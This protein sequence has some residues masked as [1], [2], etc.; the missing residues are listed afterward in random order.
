MACCFACY[1]CRLLTCLV[2]PVHMHRLEACEGSI[3]LSAP[4]NSMTA[5]AEDAKLFDIVSTNDYVEAVWARE[6]FHRL[7]VERELNLSS[8]RHQR[9]LETLLSLVRQRV[10]G[11][12]MAE[13][14]SEIQRMED[15]EATNIQEIVAAHHQRDASSRSTGRP[16]VREEDVGGGRSSITAST[17]GN[18]VEGEGGSGGDGLDISDAFRSQD[19][20]SGSGGDEDDIVVVSGQLSLPANLSSAE[21]IEVLQTAAEVQ[22]DAVGG[23]P[24]ESSPVT[25]GMSASKSSSP[26]PPP[27]D[28]EEVVEFFV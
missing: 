6:R 5:N 14:E 21:C 8:Q 9:S 28:G 13:L 16:S 2:A 7:S 22:A 20:L 3:R 12:V 17:G 26:L 25:P 19:N 1:R 15:E 4:K 24:T 11:D 10:A 18:D 23:L 27:R